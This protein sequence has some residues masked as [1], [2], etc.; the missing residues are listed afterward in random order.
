MVFKTQVTTSSVLKQNARID[1]G[2]IKIPTVE[3]QKQF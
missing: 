1:K 2:E 3:N